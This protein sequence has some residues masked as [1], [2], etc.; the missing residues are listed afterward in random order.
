M[1]MRRNTELSVSIVQSPPFSLPLAS[2]PFL[3]LPSFM[4]SSSWYFGSNP[5]LDFDI[6]AQ[7]VSIWLYLSPTRGR[8]VKFDSRLSLTQPGNPLIQVAYLV[9][10]EPAHQPPSGAPALQPPPSLALLPHARHCVWSFP[11]ASLREGPL[12]KT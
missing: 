7:I 8:M 5:G 9:R 3:P 1:D 11:Q 4:P 12:K 2:S 6:V 10:V